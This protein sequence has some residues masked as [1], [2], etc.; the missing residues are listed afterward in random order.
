MNRNQCIQTFISKAEA[1]SAGVITVPHVQQAL[2]H[3]VTLCTDKEACRLLA[4]GCEH[5]LSQEPADLCRLKEWSKIIAAP[6]LAAGDLETLTNLC[7]PLG[8]RLIEKGLHSHLGGLDIGL[9]WARYG[10]AENGTLVLDSSR[11]DIRL[12][13]MISEI[14]TVL[15]GASSIA[16]TA[17]DLLEPLTR[18]FA[19]G[20][21]YTAFIT[22]ASR[23]ADI[24]RVL[25]LGVH[26]PLELHICIVQDC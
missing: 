14:H 5:P 6:D 1:V 10:I 22:G 8:I 17:D 25:A 26:G 23:T 20:P 9:T 12:A 7:R 3:V 13:G 21:N 11:E 19:D 16:A 4:S 15:I 24:E 2:E 18:L